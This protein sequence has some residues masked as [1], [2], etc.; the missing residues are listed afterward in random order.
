MKY[1]TLGQSKLRVSALGLGTM[2]FGTGEGF[3][4]LRPKVDERLAARMVAMAVERGVTLFDS[5]ARYQHGEA[6][7][8]LGRVLTPYRNDTVVSTKDPVLPDAGPARAQIVA[9]IEGSLRRL[10]VD[11]IDL[12][13][14][15]VARLDQDVEEL[16]EGL[17]DVVR[18]GL[19]REVG[20]T[21]LPSWQLERIASRAGQA[22]RAPVVAAQMS[23]SLLERTVDV[24][25]RALLEDRGIGVVAWS[26]L[27]GAFLTGKY[28]RD[29]PGGRGGRLQ[30]FHLQPLD[31]ERGFAVLDILHEIA[32]GHAVSP[33]AVALAWV[34][35]KPFVTS[36]VFGATTIEGLEANLQAADLDLTANEASA[37][38]DASA[39]PAAYPYWLY[40]PQ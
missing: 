17:D 13:Q 23:Y 39:P 4:G 37:L 26:P 24:E 14:V 16:A 20:V 19:V 21:N 28:T 8:V 35:A 2:T 33:A 11:T 27:A 18:R 29:D 31:H 7:Q 36:A 12:F 10:G 32:A 3:G 15:G 25:Y 1:T 9:S 5:A 22:A 6:E 30:T 40:Q 34:T 38:D